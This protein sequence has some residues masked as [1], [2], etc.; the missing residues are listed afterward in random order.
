[1]YNRYIPNAHGSFDRQRVPTPQREGKPSAP[2]Q[3]PADT[4]AKPAQQHHA[5]QN[6]Q[7]SYAPQNV[8][9]SKPQSKNP[10]SFLKLPERLDSGDIL[11]LLILLLLLQENGEDSMTLL[12]TLAAFFLLQ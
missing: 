5:P 10:L 9:Q 6:M 8:T 11:V 12:L 1:M 2:P 3:P 4:P 7:Q